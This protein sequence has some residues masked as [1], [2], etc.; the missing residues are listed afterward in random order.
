MTNIFSIRNSFLWIATFFALILST[1]ATAQDWKPPG[2]Q[3][4]GGFGDQDQQV[5]LSAYFKVKPGTRLGKIYVKAEILPDWHLYSTTQKKGGPKRSVIKVATTPEYEL[6]GNWEPDKEPHVEYVDEFKIDVE[7]HEIMV[8]WSAP[9]R[10][11]EGVD[12]ESLEVKVKFSGQTCVTD[13]RCILVNESLVAEFD[14]DEDSEIVVA[15]VGPTE[16]EEEE[17]GGIKVGKEPD[18]AEEIAAMAKLYQGEEKIK[19]VKLDGSTGKGTF[20][21]ALFGAF[22]GGMLLNLMPCVFP[23]LGLKVMGFV[24]QAGSDPKKIKLHGIAFAMGLIFS[25]WVLAG[26]ILAVK[27]YTGNDVNWGQ[28]MGNP[29]FVGGIV[30]MLFVL[31][32]NLAG[33]FEMGL[34]MTKVD[35][36][37][38]QKGYT[39]SFVSGIITTLV[40]TPCSGPFLGT[41]MGYTLSQTAPV[42]MFL[43]TIFGLGI[44]FPYIVLAFFPSLINKLPR[45]GA[46]METFKKLMAFTLFAAAAFFI[47]AFGSQ[48][49]VN[50]LSWY[51]MALCVIALAAFFYGKFS[52]AYIKGSKRYVWGW[53]APIIIA[54]LG[55]WMFIDAAQMEAP[56]VATQDEWELWVPGKIEK[57]LAE[58]KAIWVDYTATW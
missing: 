48:T 4:G 11:A 44:A 9:I 24:E 51:L 29:Y 53:L 30:I 34:F 45:P 31:A 33:V 8:T 43:F 17:E 21:A 52:P 2:S 13:G 54:G 36:G 56:E 18:T 7:D 42:A 50:G 58:N 19:Y 20:W 12:V 5:T 32:L 23:V 16:P 37:K 3:F 25:M 55:M 49:G 27:A 26:A 1:S 41:A 57:K 40:A 47:Q 14:G 46:W 15:E 10:F 39:G 38:A 28:Q 35:S 6:V 22:V